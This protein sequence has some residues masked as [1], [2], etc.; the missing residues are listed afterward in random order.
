M[1]ENTNQCD[2]HKLKLLRNDKFPLAGKYEPKWMVDNAMGSPVLLLTESLS[3]TMNL[4]PGM[5][6]LDMGCGTALSSIFLA[7]EFGVT[8]FANDL[9]INPSDNWKRV[10]DAGVQNQVFPIKGEAHSLPYADGFFDA[11][12][13]INSFQF[14]G[15]SDFYLCEHISQLLR[16]DGQ[17]GLVQFGP[18]K[19]FDRKV[20]DEM[21]SW[22]WPEFYYFHS[23]DWWQWHFEKTKL[24]T[25]EAGDD[26]G[27]EGVRLH[28]I[29]AKIE[30]THT[31]IFRNNK[32]FRWNRMVFKRNHSQADDLRRI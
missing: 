27:G 5:R 28:N 6:V 19:E 1:P 31:D 20:P 13:S 14:F 32:F 18:E 23:L 24:Y 7:K 8:V 12:I 16:A 10:C 15:T 11:I 17:F 4:W 21:D 3:Q 9:W 30:G 26:C 2:D 25:Y 29:W 22:W